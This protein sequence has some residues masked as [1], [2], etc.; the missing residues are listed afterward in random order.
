MQHE[1]DYVMTDQ[2][3]KKLLENSLITV[4]DF[5]KMWIVRHEPIREEDLQSAVVQVVNKVFESGVQFMNISNRNIGRLY[6][7]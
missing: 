2:M 3:T 1:Y 7:T 4:D 6:L 5:N